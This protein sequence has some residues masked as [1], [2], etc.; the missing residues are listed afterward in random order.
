MGRPN[1]WSDL[2][3][4]I[5]A[6]HPSCICASSLCRVR[7]KRME[8]ITHSIINGGKFVSWLCTIYECIGRC[9]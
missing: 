4:A 6:C 8:K 1:Q 7:F 9:K 5:L 3:A 2:L